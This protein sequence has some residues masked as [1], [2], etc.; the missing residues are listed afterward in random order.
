MALTQWCRL[1]MIIRRTTE[2]PALRVLPQPEK[3]AYVRY[4]HPGYNKPGFRNP[5]STGS[6]VLVSLRR[7]VKTTSRITRSGRCRLDHVPEFVQGLQ[8]SRQEQ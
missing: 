6:G 2:L 4:P 8:G 3:L 5:G 1:S 7:V